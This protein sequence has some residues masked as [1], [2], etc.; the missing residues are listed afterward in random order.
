MCGL[1]VPVEVNVPGW[2]RIVD[3]RGRRQNQS[4]GV[5]GNASAVIRGCVKVVSIG[6]DGALCARG[7]ASRDGPPASAARIGNASMGENLV[8]DSAA[9]STR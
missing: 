2:A 9:T 7:S 1:R 6:G 5:P 3:G 4:L 8:G